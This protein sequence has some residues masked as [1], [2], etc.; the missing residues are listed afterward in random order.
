ML[1]IGLC[2][3]SK[4]SQNTAYVQLTTYFYHLVKVFSLSRS[5]SDHKKQLTQYIVPLFQNPL[6]KERKSKII[7]VFS[8]T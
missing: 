3:K 1:S 8:Y 4:K 7:L 6:K 5:Q 2:A